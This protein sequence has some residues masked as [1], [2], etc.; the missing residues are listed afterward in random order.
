[1]RPIIGLQSTAE[2]LLDLHKDAQTFMGPFELGEPDEEEIAT[3]RVQVE[4]ELES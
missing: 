3:M 1:L 2:R 4:R